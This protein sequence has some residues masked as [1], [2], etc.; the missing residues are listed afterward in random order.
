MFRKQTG[1]FD[2][3]D[4]L[5]SPSKIVSNKPK[6][7]VKAKTSII[8]DSITEEANEDKEDTHKQALA[9]PQLAKKNLSV[10]NPAFSGII[11]PELKK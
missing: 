2:E 4:E 5:L 10:Q 8:A 1:N 11:T 3:N 7:T 9:T 6:I